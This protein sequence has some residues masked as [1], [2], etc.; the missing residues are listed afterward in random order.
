[1]DPIYDLTR[2]TVVENV[3]AQSLSLSWCVAGLIAISWFL[4][5]SIDSAFRDSKKIA[6]TNF[7]FSTLLLIVG[8]VAA[9]IYCLNKYPQVS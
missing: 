1:M 8:P 7:V 6:F 3:I 4:N 2:A 5:F 9:T